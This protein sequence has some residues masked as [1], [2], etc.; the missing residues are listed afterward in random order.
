MAK[1]IEGKIYAVLGIGRD[2]VKPIE[3]RQDAV[4]DRAAS[5]KNGD[6]PDAETVRG[7]EPPREHRAR[8]LSRS[9]IRYL[10]RRERTVSEV[11]DHL[12]GQELDG[13]G[14]RRGDRGAERAGVPRRRA[15]RARVRAGQARARAVGERADQAGARVTRGR[16]R[17]D[18]RDARRSCS[19]AAPRV[20]A[21]SSRALGAPASAVPGPPRDRR[22]R[23]RALG[24][25]LRKGYDPELALDAL[26]GY[27]RRQS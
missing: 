4:G 12:L 10:D 9:P 21:S 14:G 2:L 25:L 26:A 7:I 23:E 8:R 11:R 6:W 13:C 15:F 5:E 20:V 3:G 19:T 1:E 24:V 22:E 17:A 16:P 18:R 27:A